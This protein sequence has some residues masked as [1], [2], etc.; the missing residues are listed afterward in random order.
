MIAS[1]GYFAVFHIPILRGRDFTEQDT[2]SSP[3]VVLINE[4]FG[5]K[6]FPKEDP[7]GQQ[8]LIGKGV[9]PQFAEAARQIVGVVG[10]IRDGGLNN[11]PRPLMIVPGS[12]VTDGMTALNSN[13]GPMV[14]LVRTHGHPH[15]YI[16]AVTGHL[17]PSTHVFPR[18]R[19]APLTQY[20]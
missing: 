12:Q 15:P 17:R 1:P 5:K 4:S 3:G 8:L 14:W 18:S 16:P 7:V 10:D 11:D 2:G 6:F 13:I 9:G 20:L 19:L